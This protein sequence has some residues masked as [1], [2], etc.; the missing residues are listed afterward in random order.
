MSQY[1]LCSLETTSPEDDNIQNL[2]LIEG[3]LWYFFRKNESVH[4][5]NI[6]L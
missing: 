5:E 6:L 2:K 1:Q 3:H 4:H